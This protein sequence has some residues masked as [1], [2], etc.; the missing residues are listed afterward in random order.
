MVVITK[1]ADLEDV[2]DLLGHPIPSLRRIDVC[3][4]RR[5]GGASLDIVIAEPLKDDDAS[6]ARLLDK[7]DAYFQHIHSPEFVAEAGHPS[8]ATIEIVVNIHRA[9][10][11]EAFA[12]LEK[13]RPWA[14][15]NDAS[16]VVKILD[17]VQD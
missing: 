16:L 5:T 6:L 2:A 11:R 4:I 3:T 1:H 8:P 15:E 13:S 12:L 10:C 14:A 9:S 7:L 17:D